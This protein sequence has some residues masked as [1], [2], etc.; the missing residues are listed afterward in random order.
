MN[1][2]RGRVLM[3][4]LMALCVTCVTSINAETVKIAVDHTA[5]G[6]IDGDLNIID[7]SINVATG[8]LTVNG[9][10]KITGGS[11]TV[12]GALAQSNL[13]VFGDLI[14]TNTYPGGDASVIVDGTLEVTGEI[15]LESKDGDANISTLGWWGG[16]TAGSIITRGHAHADVKANRDIHVVG[17]I[18]TKSMTD[19]ACVKI[20][21]PGAYNIFAGSIVTNGWDDS[22]VE[23]TGQVFVVGELNT[24][25]R[26]HDA[27]VLGREGVYAGSITTHAKI[28]GYVG[29]WTEWAE[30]E[31]K[32][33]LCTTALTGNGSVYSDG[34]ITAGA[35]VTNAYLQAY[36]EASENII[37]YGDLITRSEMAAAD[38]YSDEGYIVAANIVTRGYSDAA[39]EAH[40]KIDV[41]RDIFTYSTHGQAYVL[42]HGYNFGGPYAPPPLNAEDIRAYRIT[43]RG[44]D[45][46]NGSSAGSVEARS[47]GVFVRGPIRTRGIAGNAHVIA[48]GK[49][50]EAESI[51][52]HGYYNAYVE[53]EEGDIFV[54]DLLETRSDMY[55]AH[56][57]AYY[58]VRARSIKTL[59]DGPGI[60]YAYVLSEYGDVIVDGD[61]R[62]KAA[63]DSAYVKALNGDIRARSIQTIAGC[64]SDDSIQADSA[65]GKFQWFPYTQDSDNEIEIKDSVFYL[66]TDHEWNITLNIVGTCTLNGNGHKLTFTE[67][68]K[69]RLDE[70]AELTLR[71]FVINN[72][73]DEDIELPPDGILHLE[74]VTINLGGD[75][76]FDGG[77]MHI[78]GDFVVNGPG[79]KFEYISPAASYIEKSSRWRLGTGVTLFYDP[80][81]SDDDR[82]RFVDQTS[83]INFDG[84]MFH[85]AKDFLFTRGTIVYDNHV[86]FSAE[87]D[88]TIYFGDNDPAEN[89]HH[90]C[91]LRSQFSIHGHLENDNV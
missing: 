37:V 68:G 46:D 85:A 32:G 13:T 28:E 14:V 12:S 53:S 66:D 55:D 60:G 70:E 7:G 2:V 77:S 5:P 39:I 75:F 23:C 59:S 35:I 62:T 86:T 48:R 42:C 74:D 22:S 54:R 43:T 61:I 30:V 57:D 41:R 71:N 58:D 1:R 20:L 15:I 10:V 27:Y 89:I 31:V 29:T 25:S 82:I 80:E 88:R 76:T 33:G 63:C 45:D 26:N 84:A 79:Y 8:S 24:K 38:I 52:T 9:D 91:H 90:D 72:F 44:Y 18:D 36:V 56:V 49:S 50:V 17:E 21:G 83:E 6:V 81:G 16:I 19:E 67:L 87:V 11:V 3:S 40:A 69:I 78:Y 65:T 64:G 4:M 47:G 34:T 73:D 51:F